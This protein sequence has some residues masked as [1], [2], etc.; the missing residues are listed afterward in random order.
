MTIFDLVFLDNKYNIELACIAL[1]YINTSLKFFFSIYSSF[2]KG[3][4]CTVNDLAS[5]IHP[6]F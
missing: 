4:I 6:S 1:E 2:K 3:R 5:D